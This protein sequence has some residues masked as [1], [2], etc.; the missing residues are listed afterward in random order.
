VA[1]PRPGIR[2]PNLDDLEKRLPGIS[3]KVILMDRPR[4]DISAS[5]VRMMAAQGQPIEGLVPG[6]VA[7]YIEK[8]KL[9]KRD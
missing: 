7:A 6:P 5:A 1:V 3:R 4:L 8:H 2:R 9:Y